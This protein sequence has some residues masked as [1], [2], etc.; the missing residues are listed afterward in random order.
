MLDNL[1]EGVL[2]PDIY[3]PLLNPLYRD[4]LQHYGTVPLPCRV[5][6]ADRKA[7]VSYCTSSRLRKGESWLFGSSA[8]L[9]F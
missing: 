2:A 1:R 3:D 8:A 6:H 5:G 7:Y 9:A 4:V